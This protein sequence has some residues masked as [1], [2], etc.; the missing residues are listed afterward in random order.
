MSTAKDIADRVAAA[1]YETVATRRVSDQAWEAY[2]D[3]IDARIALLRPG[4]SEELA[5]VLD[6][7]ER[8][9]ALWRAHS[10][11]TGYL[12]SVVRPA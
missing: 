12:L 4:A 2:Y 5:A 7:A 11:E 8:E 3:P 6:E 10:H 1:G 9:A